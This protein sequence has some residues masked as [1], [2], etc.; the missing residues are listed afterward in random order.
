MRLLSRI[1]DIVTANLHDLIEQYEDPELLLQQAVREM[2]ESLRGALEHAVKVVA[3]EKVLARQLAS[4]QAT[5]RLWQQRATSAV[6][7]GDDA[8]ARAALR[9][10][11]EREACCES[12]VAQLAEATLAA[13]TLRQQI[14]TLRTRTDEAKRKLVLLAARQRAATTRQRLLREFS[15]VPLGENSFSKFE[16][17]CRKV[18]QTEAEA[19]AL[20]ELAGDGAA[21]PSIAAAD[22]SAVNDTVNEA[23]IEAELEELKARHAGSAQLGA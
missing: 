15:A 2:D 18:E 13:Q 5:A 22:I 4:E 11:R 3:H 19:D 6:Q 7:R 20:A 8:A 12:L 10:K 1:A 9:H 14:E 21:C 17:M 16:R 23:A